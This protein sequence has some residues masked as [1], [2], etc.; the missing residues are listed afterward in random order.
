VTEPVSAMKSQVLGVLFLLLL[1]GHEAAL[2]NN[3]ISSTQQVRLAT[4]QQHKLL[5]KAKLINDMSEITLDMI[6][7]LALGNICFEATPELSRKIDVIEEKLKEDA[8]AKK[9]VDLLEKHA[10]VHHGKHLVHRRTRTKIAVIDDILVVLH[11]VGL[12]VGIFE[13]VRKFLDGGVTAERKVA[14]TAWLGTAEAALASALR[15]LGQYKTYFEAHPPSA[16]HSGIIQADLAELDT[17]IKLMNTA[18]ETVAKW[19]KAA[20]DESNWEYST[21]TSVWAGIF[22]LGIFN[23][24]DKTQQAINVSVFKGRAFCASEALP[25]LVSRVTNAQNALGGDVILGGFHQ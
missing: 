6:I 5:T 10:R 19:M 16:H 3:A 11:T 22:T 4:Q 8:V 15:K 2:I 14:L 21:S 9:G 25:A 12:G 1:T 7:D 23:I 24:V 18:V 17:A 13:S 20:V